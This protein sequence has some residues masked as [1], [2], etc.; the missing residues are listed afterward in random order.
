VLSLQAEPLSTDLTLIAAGGVVA[1]ALGGLL[2]CYLHVSLRR[3]VGMV[4]LW[5]VIV[6]V[7]AL[8]SVSRRP[9]WDEMEHLH[10]AYLLS[11]GKLPY[12]QFWEHH[13][14]ALWIALA[15]LMK[16]FPPGVWICDFARV[17]ALLISLAACA[18]AVLMA[19]RLHRTTAVTPVVLFLWLASVEPLEFYNLRPDIPANVL[20]M[21]AMLMVLTSRASWR[22]LSGG[23]LLGLS[24]SLMPKHLPLVAVLPLVILWEGLGP[25]NVAR[26][27]ALHGLGIVLGLT[28]LFVWLNA[29]DLVGQFIFWVLEFNQDAN[30]QVGGAFPLIPALLMAAWLVRIQANHWTRLLPAERM[31]VAA[32]LA[33]GAMYIMEPF[34]KRMYGQQ[35]F[36]LMAIA[37]GSLEAYRGFSALLQTRRHWVAGALVGLCLA[38]TSAVVAYWLPRGDYYWGRIEVAT[39]IAQARGGP[40][41]M[42]SPDHPIFATDATDLNQPW[43][44]YK[45]LYRPEIKSRLAGIVDRIIAARP[46]MILA[47]QSDLG[48]RDEAE[49]FSGP[50]VRGLLPDRLVL[51]GVVTRQDGDRL[52]AFIEDNYRLVL[53]LRHY[54]WVRRDLPAAN[55]WVEPPRPTE[56][57]GAEA[58]TDS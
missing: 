57:E 14:P 31:L 27:V 12:T 56:P 6:A 20:S 50:V 11:Q 26:I 51:A 19:Q 33:T 55:K 43:Q 17:A 2:W 54:Y 24:L 7:L 49:P 32:L 22:V 30:L 35:M 28:P 1:F 18:L 16:A 15:P 53:I 5:A 4:V 34:H 46:T 13:S 25:R 45:W 21:G 39:L 29:R 10:S 42:V 58:G 44:W 8:V 23:V 37:V 52:Q 48:D 47:G 41:M 38:R 3:R 9:D 36:L 40:V